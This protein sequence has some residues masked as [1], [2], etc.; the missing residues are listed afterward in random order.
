M[1][2]DQSIRPCLCSDCRSFMDEP[3][4]GSRAHPSSGN[5]LLNYDLKQTFQNL[6]AVWRLATNAP[7]VPNPG[8]A[9]VTTT[10]AAAPR[11]PALTT[12]RL[13]LF[14]H[15]HPRGERR[16]NSV[17]LFARQRKGEDLISTGRRR[18]VNRPH[19]QLTASAFG[20]FTFP[21]FACAAKSF[22]VPVQVSR[23]ER[24]FAGPFARSFST[25]R[26]G[27]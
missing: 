22:V 18:S 24:R 9:A 1:M 13:G 14:L 11:S 20:N 15:P 25:R 26:S 6:R 8:C 12:K 7:S 16:A 5:P 19:P 10:C 17:S 2:A 23:S 3:K 4:R 21:G 27:P